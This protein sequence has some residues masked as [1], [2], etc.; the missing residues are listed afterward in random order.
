MAHSSIETVTILVYDDGTVE[1][2]ESGF[3]GKACTEIADIIDAALK[4]KAVKETKTR[5][6]YQGGDGT[7][8]TINRG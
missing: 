4:G 8:R 7:K 3:K 1:H 5:E 2:T 6:Y